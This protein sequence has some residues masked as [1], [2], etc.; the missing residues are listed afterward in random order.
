ME[1]QLSLESLLSNV[2]LRHTTIIRIYVTSNLKFQE[3]LMKVFASPA[4][5]TAEQGLCIDVK[6]CELFL[7]LHHVILKGHLRRPCDTEGIKISQNVASS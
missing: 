4:P 3:D 5:N 1:V 6:G 7:L 2:L